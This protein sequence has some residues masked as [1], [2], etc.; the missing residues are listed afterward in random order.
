L[1]WVIL[2]IF[3]LTYAGITARR[4]AL[5]P[6]GRPSVALVGAC[7]LVIA[8]AFAGPVGLSPDEALAAVEPHTL[9]LLFGMMVVAA[10]F[11]AAGFFD[12]ATA[13]LTRRVRSRAA[14]LWLTTFGSG[15]LSAAL[16]NDAVCLLATP[17]VVRLARETRT[18]LH[19]LLFAV[20]MGSNA[21]SALTLSGNPQNMLV[22][23][24]SDLSYRGYLV[25]AAL[26]A[27]VALTL[28]AAALHLIHRR[29]L[30][31]PDPEAT[32]EVEPT[33]IDRKLLAATI[34]ALAGVVA[35]NLAGAS[36]AWSA[37]VGASVVLIAGG[38]HAERLLARVDWSVIVFFAGLFVVVAALQ[39]TGLPAEWLGALGGDRSL[40]VLVIVLAVGSQIVSNV[41]LILLLAPYIRSF[42][43]PDHAWSVT[44]LVT[45]LA[46]NLTLLGS[47]ANIIV[48]EQARVRLGF[49][50]YLRIGVPVTVVSTAAAVAL[51]ALLVG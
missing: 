10:G 24:L 35:A 38:V 28:T 39:K 48:M 8:G 30:A 16:L 37:L 46:G 27:L 25:E 13:F 26:P 17:L 15:L 41:P 6:I 51:H 18:A 23:R 21:G 1:R 4:V 50:E 43:D 3:A 2:A 36:L 12:W 5:L 19:P 20:A 31:V 7:A 45:T 9:T 22:A 29:A 14:L 40:L 33:P 42:P 49:W 47:V 34:V 44:A 11:G 32:L